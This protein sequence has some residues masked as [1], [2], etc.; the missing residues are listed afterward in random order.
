[1]MITR[2]KVHNY[3]GMTPDLQTPRELWVTMVDCLKGVIEDFPEFI[4]QRS[5][6]WAANHLFN[7]RPEDER[8]ILNEEQTTEFHHV[9]AQLIF[10]TSRGRKYIKTTINF[11]CIR[12]RIPD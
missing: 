6:R 3:L 12:E 9:V 7:V 5:T 11:L 10:V 4:T 8:T 1:M 2:G